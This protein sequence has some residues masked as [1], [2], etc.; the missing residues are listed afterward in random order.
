MD[1]DERWSRSLIRVA[2]RSLRKGNLEARA[3]RNSSSHKHLQMCYEIEPEFIFYFNRSKRRLSRSGKRNPPP[4]A[5]SRYPVVAT[6]DICSDKSASEDN[7]TSLLAKK[8]EIRVQ[9]TPI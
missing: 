2:D 5:A 6:W 7:L 3:R 4:T 8:C 9:C 1:E